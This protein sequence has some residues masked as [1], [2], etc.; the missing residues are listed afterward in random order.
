MISSN[1]ASISLNERMNRFRLASRDI[2]N[3]HFRLE[4]PYDSASAAWAAEERFVEVQRVLFKNLVVE[5]VPPVAPRQYGEVQRWI[6]VRSS[7]PS[8]AIPAMINRDIDSGYWDHSV[9]E[10]STG[11]TLVFVSFFDWDQLAI[12]DNRYVRVLIAE[13]A[14]K[15]E[16]VGRHALIETYLI[17]F[18]LA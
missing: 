9:R 16:I 6:S 2:F 13:S 15:P 3:Q 11:S 10:I 18:E 1:S 5:P 14:D 4:N 12:R 7:V 17:R 8:T